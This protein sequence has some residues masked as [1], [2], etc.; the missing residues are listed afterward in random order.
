MLFF[1]FRSWIRR[2]FST[3]SASKS[4]TLR[5]RQE[6]RPARARVGLERLEDRTLLTNVLWDGGGGDNLWTT[7]QNWSG[8]VVPGADDDVTINVGDNPTVRL[9]AGDLTVKSLQTSEALVLSGH[10]LQVTGAF[11]VDSQSLTLG[12]GTLTTGGLT[13]NG[14]ILNFNGGT[15]AL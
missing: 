4:P 11:Q 3:R 6:G 14:A 9:N 15:I 2:V 8:D 10:S 12:A 5:R 1:S 7:A 13:V